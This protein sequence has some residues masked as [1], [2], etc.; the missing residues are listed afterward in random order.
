MNYWAIAIILAAGL[1][2]C[3]KWKRDT[4]TKDPAETTAE[5]VAEKAKLYVDLEYSAA[6]EQGFYHSKC[7]GLLFTTLR[8]V[9]TNRPQ[10]ETIMQAM[11]EPGRWYRHALHD[12]YSS[13]GSPADISNDMLLGLALYAWHFK[14]LD[15]VTGVINYGKEHKWTMGDGDPFRAIMRPTLIATYYDISRE[16]GAD[17][18]DPPK[19]ASLVPDGFE[20]HLATVHAL[21]RALVLG[22]A[23]QSDLDAFKAQAERQP[24]NALF[25]A[26]YHLYLDGDQKA[27]VEA[28]AD[29]VLFP[30][31]RL[32]TVADRCEEYLYQRDDKPNDWGPCADKAAKP[33]SGTDLLF[34]LAVAEN[35]LRKRP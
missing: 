22:G 3:S 6:D 34:A 10:R 1:S 33:H 8:A 28:L 7:D 5:H 20:A 17:P 21:L 14:D 2:G 27:A 19:D 35:K 13:G 16:L 12:C 24:K 18:G 26:A 31:D 30:P 23:S 4:D 32:P 25:Q 15:I 29:D 11:S 9:A